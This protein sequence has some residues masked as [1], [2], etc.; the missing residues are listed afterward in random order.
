MGQPHGTRQG[1]L[2]KDHELAH[3]LLAAKDV[4]CPSFPDILPYSVLATWPVASHVPSSLGANK[5][6]GCEILHRR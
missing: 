6:S 5:D 4:L 3:G 2:R 1:I